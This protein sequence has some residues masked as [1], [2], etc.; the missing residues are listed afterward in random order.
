MTRT[1]IP[2]A[3]A[4]A[5]A[6]FL[7][8]GPAVPA[9]ADEVLR[10]N[11]VALDALTAADTDPLTESRIFAMFHAAIH[12]AVNAVEP[13]YEPWRTGLA[14]APGASAPAAAAAAAHAVLVEL[15]PK[16]RVSFDAALEE[17]LK[18]VANADARERGAETGRRAAAAV[19]AARRDDGMNRTVSPKPGTQPGEYRPTPP[20][21][22]PA[23]MAQFGRITPFTL[24]DPA[25]FRPA[26]PPAVGSAEALRD[27]EEVRRFGAQ[28]SSARTEEQS[29]IAKFWYENSTRGWNR[30]A[31]V[32]SAERGLDLWDNARLFA[33]V[34]FAMADGFIAGFDA[35]YHYAY[36][37]PVTA[38]REAGDPH[39]LS[40]LW[41]PPVPD[42]PSTHTVL[43]AAVATA[44]ARCL[45]TDFVAFST[46]SGPP[47]AGVTR[48][49]WSLS[50]AAHENGASRVLAGIHFGTAVRAGYRLGEQVGAWAADHALRP[51]G[52]GIASATRTGTRSR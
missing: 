31:Q 48:R 43:G 51:I 32:V 4:L 15:M 52:Q 16:A 8:A 40:N 13:R 49:F 7:L 19:L 1:W 37:R 6:A 17:A 42:Y 25:Q 3:A 26:P 2:T 50:E 45:G 10:W 27:L 9:R 30:V 12:D 14:A 22:T 11:R 21:L 38:I 29:E 46:T 23:F 20:D 18:R 36:W 33:L 44:I 35:K 24:R 39:W 28:G 34:N 5:V 47:Y 41:T